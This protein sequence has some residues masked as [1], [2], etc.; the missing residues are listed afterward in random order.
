MLLCQ[1]LGIWRAKKVRFGITSR[2]GGG[3]KQGT[4]KRT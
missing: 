2:E 4:F 3:K 1:N